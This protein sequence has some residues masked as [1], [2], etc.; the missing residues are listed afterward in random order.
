[1]LPGFVDAQNDTIDGADGD[2]DIIYAYKGDDI[3]D[4]GAGDD[5]VF[6]GQG[7]DTLAGGTGT[8]ELYG[9]TGRDVFIGGDGADAF[10]GGAD[11][12]NLDYSNSGSAVNVDLSTSS[13]S[14]GDADNDTIIGGI[15]GVI[16]SDYDDVL[17]GFDQ[18][19]TNPSDIYSNEFFGGGGDDLITGLDGDDLIDGGDDNDTL[20]GGGGDDEV[21]G[22]DG[23]DFIDTS[24]L[25]PLPDRAYP[26]IF[27]ADRDPSDDNDFVDGGDGNDTIITGDDADSILGGDGNDTI[28]AGFDDDEIDGGDGD[29][30][31]VGGEGADNIDGGDGDDTIY[32][33]LDPIYPDTLNIPDAL[34]LRPDNGTDTIHGGDGDDTIFGQDD[35]DVIYGDAGDD[36]LDGGIDDD[37]I[38][39]GEDDDV[40][41]GGEGSDDLYGGD[42]SDTFI[43]NSADDGDGDVIDGGTDGVDVDTLDLTG[44]GS[45]QITG[46][47]VDAD[48]DSTSGTI[49]FLDAPGGTVTGT[50][51]FAEIERIIPCFTPGTSIATLRGEVP[52]EDLKVGDKVIT[53]DNGAQEIRWVGCKPMSALELQSS[54]HLQPIRIQKGSL[55]NGLPERDLLVSPNHKVLISKPEVGLLFNEPEVLVPAK[56]LVKPS[57]GIQAVNLGATSYIHIMFDNHEVVL[58]NG[59]WTESFQ[60]G[61]QA[62]D[63]V[64]GESRNEILE[65]FPELAFVDGREAYTAARMTLKKFEADMLRK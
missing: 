9:G 45:F 47:T 18:Q 24:G 32:G 50:L 44:A 7:S 19:G 49:E 5:L 16:G 38:Y 6:G 4:A 57:D 53:R 35:D 46:E 52:V 43:V 37:I 3:V 22:G 2:D 42:D 25:S 28:N 23:N 51:D 56:H 11:H 10:N 14:G 64:D 58:S 63:S 33:G 29:D 26:G 30:F 65:L 48:G 12:D 61:D 17:T 34:D 36:V 54:K 59:A 62:L 20:Y 39:G 13:L 21:Y 40:L 55:G 60:P 1:M 31:I 41:T 27:P 8:N 15:D